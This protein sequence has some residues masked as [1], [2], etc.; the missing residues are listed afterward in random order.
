MTLL[1][2]KELVNFDPINSFSIV[3]AGLEAVVT[4]AARHAAADS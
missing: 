1:S 2:A 4:I 3:Y